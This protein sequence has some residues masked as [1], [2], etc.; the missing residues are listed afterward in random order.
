MTVNWSVG[1]TMDHPAYAGRT[2]TAVRS[3]QWE[4]NSTSWTTVPD[5]SGGNITIMRST[6]VIFVCCHL[7]TEVDGGDTGFGLARL[8]KRL[9]NGSWSSVAQFNITGKNDNSIGNGFQYR[10]DH[11]ESA[12]TLIAFRVQYRKNQSGG[13]HTIADTGPGESTRA[14]LI[15]WEMQE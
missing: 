9:N 11:N 4:M 10:V 6:S 12:D 8:Q 2:E 5:L 14:T 1:G 7:S 15:Y 3:S 13:N